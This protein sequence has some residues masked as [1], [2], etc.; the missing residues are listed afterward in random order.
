MSD[1]SFPARI[2]ID[3]E[4]DLDGVPMLDATI[5]PTAEAAAQPLPAGPRGDPGPRGVPR[6]TFVK[7]GT[8]PNAAARPAG[9]GPDDRGKWWHRLDTGGMDTWTGTA[10]QHSPGAVGAQGPTADPAM[11]TTTTVHAAAI[12]NPA[13][14]VTAN[15]AALAV[16]ATAPAGLQGDPGP[17]GSS[18][19]LSTATDFDTTI[20]PTHRATFG[21]QAAAR[22]WKVAPPPGGFG[23]WAWYQ[24]DFAANLNTSAATITAGRFT[25]PTLPFAWRPLVWLTGYI[26]CV[27]TSTTYPILTGRLNTPA[28]VMVAYGAGIRAS[29]AL[30]HVTAPPKFG[31]D[32]P[33]SLSP[34][35]TYGTIP[36]GESASLLVM[37][38]KV[39]GATTNLVWD[40]ADASAVVWALPIGA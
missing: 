24:D 4:P 34:S 19:H 1:V 36:A 25:L 3:S 15:G 2:T 16:Q 18:G 28:G 22:R 32:G 8:I 26:Q 39:G 9:L 11:I 33:K 14:T 20:G 30:Y 10:W 17:V 5:T 35:S 7:M 23:P 31:D 29:A 37:V 12:T 6:A 40:R 27:E 13:V 38:E 21:Y